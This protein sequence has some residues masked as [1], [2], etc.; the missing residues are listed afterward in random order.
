MPRNVAERSNSNLFFSHESGDA[1]LSGLQ[2]LAKM[3]IDSRLLERDPD[4]TTFIN[5]RFL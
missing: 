3:M 2:N 4:W 5:T 1:F